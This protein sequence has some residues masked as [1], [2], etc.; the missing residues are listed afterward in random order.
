[1]TSQTQEL[2]PARPEAIEAAP[3]T[4]LELMQRAE[5]DVQISTAHAFPRSLTRFFEKAKAMAT[6]DEDTAVSCIYRRPVGKEDGKMKFAEGESIRLA[7]IV[8]ASYGN[9][10]VQGVISEVTPRYVK[11]IGMAHDLESNYAAKAEVA[12]PTV[13]KDGRPYSENMR[14]V[15]AKAAQSKAIRDA[16]FRV[17]PKSLCKPIIAAAREVIAGTQK[18]MVERRALV[19]KWITTLSVGKERVFAALGISGPEEMT[20]EMLEDLTG[21]RTSVRDNDTTLDE[22]FPPIAENGNSTQAGTAGLKERLKGKKEGPPIDPDLEA[23][24]QAQIDALKADEAAQQQPA[25]D[26][27]PEQTECRY[28]CECGHEFDTPKGKG[29]CPQCL[30]K[31]IVDRQAAA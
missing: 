15:V 9:I 12:E 24:K 26:S 13:T 4:A 10:R 1:M 25:E 28:V 2:V 22:S 21:I 3:A 18:P 5:I 14:I 8:A 7:E 11:A 27:Q 29:L 6:V 17:I 19:M 16:I 31:K 23:A 20:A 30:G